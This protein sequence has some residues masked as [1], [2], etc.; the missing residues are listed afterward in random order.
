MYLFLT[1]PRLRGQAIKRLQ[2]M[3]LHNGYD[4]GGTGADGVYGKNTMRAVVS[5]QLSKNMRSDGVVDLETWRAIEKSVTKKDDLEG[6]LKT[7]VPG[8][9]VDISKDHQKPRLY[10]SGRSPRS[11]GSITGVTLHQTGCTLSEAQTRWYPLNAHIGVLKNGTILL[12]NELTDFIWHAQGFSHHTIGIEFNGNFW[13]VDT[14]NSTW[15]AGGGP[16]SFLTSEQ[17]IA[18]KVLLRYLILRF[19]ENNAVF[20]RVYAHRQASGDRLADPGSE[21]W[22]LVA[23]PWMEEIGATDGGPEFKYGTGR[24]IPKEWNSKYTHG[25]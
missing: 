23:M 1:V 2:E 19:S 3:L 18:S 10:S 7:P 12:V 5:F 24:P 21:I 9:I 4:V 22:R 25:Y 15:W 8:T 13:G 6:T 16:A 17:K 20:K 14:D 11:W